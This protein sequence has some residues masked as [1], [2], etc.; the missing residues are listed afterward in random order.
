[1]KKQTKNL[2][3]YH[4]LIFLLRLRLL[5]L[6]REMKTLKTEAAHH[7]STKKEEG[8]SKRKYLVK[9]PK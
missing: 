8:S 4:S 6:S 3:E 2:I 1:L 9:I 7:H 5:N